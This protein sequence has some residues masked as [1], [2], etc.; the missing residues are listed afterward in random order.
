MI[1]Q[2]DYKKQ[3]HLSAAATGSTA[4]GPATPC[5]QASSWGRL[6]SV[7]ILGKRALLR[8]CPG[9]NPDLSSL[10]LP[11]SKGSQPQGNGEAKLCIFLVSQEVYF[12]FFFSLKR[13][14]T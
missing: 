6:G 1:F 2:S 8:A 13:E 5:L 7:L 3:F 9:G 12:Y 10:P 11:T 4:L 14:F